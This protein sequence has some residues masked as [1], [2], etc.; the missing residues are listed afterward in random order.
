MKSI[1]AKIIALAAGAA[2]IVTIGLSAVFGYLFVSASNAQISALEATLREDYDRLIKSQVES[3]VS[4]V[5]RIGKMRTS[6]ELGPEAAERLARDLLRDLRYGKDGYFWADTTE[7]VNKVLLGNASEGT[8]RMNL[9]DA[10]GFELVKAIIGAALAGGGYTDYW[11]PRPGET[12]AHSKRGYSKL[13]PSFNWV[14][15]TGNYID[16]IEKVVA[17]KR[18]EADA[19]LR[20]AVG[21]LVPLAAFLAAV[22]VLLAVVVGRRIS[23]PLSYAVERVRRISEGDLTGDFD[24]S[25]LARPD[26]A[27]RIVRGLSSMRDD[28]SRLIGQAAQASRRVAQGSEQ[29]REAATGISDGASRQAAG[30]EEVSASVE[31][32]SATARRNAENAR[33]TAVIASEAAREAAE[34]ED[35]FRGAAEALR[36]IADRIG[37]I[38]E[39]ARQTNL[40]ALNAAIEAAR[41]GESGKGFAVVAGEVR[42]LAERSGKA[43]EEIRGISA[44][45]QK[46]SDRAL[47]SLGRLV[48]AIRRTSTLVEEIGAASREQEIGTDQISKAVLALDEVVQQNAAAAEELAASAASL[49]EESV[50]LEK[51]ISSFKTEGR[52]LTL[53]GAEDSE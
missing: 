29:F 28:L 2:L 41:A 50:R 26:E 3:A 9:K 34:S 19:R 53:I 12:E 8:N 33:E 47:G 52:A 30:A 45:T 25:F 5:E 31:E 10:K 35:S 24:P 1:T 40:L 42:K 14:V 17:Q 13:A 49:S 43:A 21:A 7:G 23:A 16:D 27:G 22:M 36:S 46:Q 48:P 44:D 32:L 37:V 38:E 6:G 20:A 4:L 18:T 11:F 51:A 15:G 39:I